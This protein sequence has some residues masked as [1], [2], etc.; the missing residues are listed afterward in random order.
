MSALGAG[1]GLL[2]VLVWL[3]PMAGQG[4]PIVGLDHIPLAVR[5]IDR[6][7]ETCR[8]LGFSIKPWRFHA[9]GI[10]NAHVKFPD[11]PG[12]E[13]ITATEAVDPLTTRYR[14]LLALREGPASFALHAR[15]SDRLIAA[16]RKGYEFDR[17]GDLTEIR[18]PGLDWLFVVRDN[19]SP[20]DRPQHFDHPN[21]AVAF[22]S[23]WIATDAREGLV[24]LPVDLG[25]A[26]SARSRPCRNRRT[27]SS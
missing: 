5:D 1:P 13:L 19:R 15:D 25:G 17:R 16:P 26:R 23:I 18:Q 2:L 27:R 7:V 11:G 8:R 4:R 20:T 9:N 6:A 14:A 10:R 3:A 12:P 22:Q 21:G 24:R